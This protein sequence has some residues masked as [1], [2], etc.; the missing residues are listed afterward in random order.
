MTAWRT[1]FE[2]MPKDRA[3]VVIFPKR[4][5]DPL[6]VYWVDSDGG[7][8]SAVDSQGGFDFEPTDLLAWFDLP[9][10]EGISP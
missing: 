2:N 7:F 1:D 8:W 9:A 4:P 3:C 10:W 5:D 6:M